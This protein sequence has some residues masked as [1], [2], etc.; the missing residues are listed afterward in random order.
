[1][2]GSRLPL[3]FPE[4]VYIPEIVSVQFRPGRGCSASA[5]SC[6][7]IRKVHCSVF[8]KVR[9]NKD[10]EQSPLSACGNGRESGYGMGLV[11][12]NE[13]ECSS[14]FGYEYLAGG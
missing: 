12:V 7:C 2:S 13:Y 1:M 3:H 14:A 4:Y 6:R 9:V 11:A 8:S 5:G 10:I